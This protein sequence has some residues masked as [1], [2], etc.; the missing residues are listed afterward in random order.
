MVGIV[1]V[2]HSDTLAEGVVRLARE[3]APADLKLEAAGGIGESGVLGTS[4]ELV[5]AAIERS[6]SADGVLVLMDLG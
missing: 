2:S 1:V 5:R 3:M 6:M 4:A